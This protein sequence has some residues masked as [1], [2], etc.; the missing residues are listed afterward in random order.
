V[1]AAEGDYYGMRVAHVSAL[2]DTQQVVAM[3]WSMGRGV[4]ASLR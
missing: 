1:M 2:Y 3:M 4:G